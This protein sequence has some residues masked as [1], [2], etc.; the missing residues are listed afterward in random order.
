MGAPSADATSSPPPFI[1]ALGGRTAVA[2]ET[3]RNGMFGHAGSPLLSP[4]PVVSGSKAARLPTARPRAQRP[5]EPVWLADALRTIEALPWVIEN[6]RGWSAA[7]NGPARANAVAVLHAM[8]DVAPA[9]QPTDIVPMADE[10]IVIWLA[11]PAAAGL[12]ASI[13]CYNSGAIVFGLSEGDE[14]HAWEIDRGALADEV[15]G[16]AARLSVAAAGR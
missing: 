16:L 12:P 3:L 10:G 1:S 8:S 14:D 15:R 11:A 6:W 5:A 9:L 2:D 7:P 13:E 4:S